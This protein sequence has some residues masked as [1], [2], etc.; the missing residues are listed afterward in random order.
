MTPAQTEAYVDAAATALGLGLRTEHRPGVIG[1]FTL[2]A[3]MA[4]L[5]EAVPLETHAESAMA[6]APVVPEG[7]A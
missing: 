1:F 4:E 2:A 3:G 7:Q 6:F 5:V